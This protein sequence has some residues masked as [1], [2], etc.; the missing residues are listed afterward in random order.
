MIVTRLV[1]G[2]GNQLFQFAAGR[3]LAARLG[4]ELVLDSTWIEGEGGS[5]PGTARRYCLDRFDLAFELTRADRVA[6]PPARTRL[7]FHLRRWTPS[8][9]PRLTALVEEISD[10][11]DLRVLAAPDNT[12]LLG[13][14][15]SERFFGTTRI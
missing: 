6:V 12:Q 1:G 11:L 9:K 15:E 4:V 10:G 7:G 14:W 3:S 13:F 8:R 5:G 2:L